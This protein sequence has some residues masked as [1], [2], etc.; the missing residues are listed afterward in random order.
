[1]VVTSG[2]RS[3]RARWS[4]GTSPSHRGP[5]GR[6]A[7][8]ALGILAACAL[9]WGCGSAPATPIASAAGSPAALASPA[10]PPVLGLDWGKATAV[11]RPE[12]AFAE[13]SPA[14][15]ASLDPGIVHS[16]H[17]L[18]F[19]GQAIMADVARLSTGGLVAV[20]YV[21]P[22]WH[23]VAW[24][25]DDGASWSLRDMGSTEFTFPE[26]LAVGEGGGVV[27]VGRSGASPLAW[28][29]ADGRSWQSHP[30]AILGNGTVAE[31]MTAVVATPDG[32]LGGGSVGPELAERHARFWSS[33]DGS[34]WQPIADDETP[35]AN[36]EVRSIVRFHGG[37]VAVGFVGSAQKVTGSV[38]WTSRD[39]RSWTRIDAPDLARGRAVAL[40]EA[41]SGGLVAVGSDLVEHEADAWTSPD[42]RS[43]TLAPSEPSR[44]YHGKIRMTDVTVVGDELIGVG[45]Y[46]GL[47]RG[48]AISWVSRDGIAWQEARSAPVQEQGEF[49]AVAAAGPGVVAVGSFGEP[50]DYIP[51]V[52]LSPAR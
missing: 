41:P 5:F 10:G 48:T 37:Y 52:W 35:F 6:G 17:P 19:P 15:D 21:Y 31:R 51:T 23:P 2:L 32:F 24:T 44:Q 33:S 25:S 26:A 39:G 11:D 50:D 46:I 38:A 43:W 12:D 30:V 7:S 4:G 14:S 47:Q 13:R 28:T 9:V 3:R 22:R 45:N 1:M 34:T 8:A 42:G 27:A 36:A 18:H 40:V 29:S 16:G 49:Y 20:G